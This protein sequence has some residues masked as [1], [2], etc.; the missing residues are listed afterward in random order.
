MERGK[1]KKATAGAAGA[2]GGSGEDKRDTF[3][4][5]DFYELAEEDPAEAGRLMAGALLGDG[6]DR[7]SPFAHFIAS[8]WRELL[9]QTTADESPPDIRAMLAG[10]WSKLSDAEKAAFTSPPS[11][12]A[13]ARVTTD[14]ASSSSTA[15]AV[16]TAASTSAAVDR[17]PLEPSPD[18]GN[19]YAEKLR[20]FV[21]SYLSALCTSMST[22]T[23][24]AWHIMHVK[25]SCS[26]IISILTSATATGIAASVSSGRVK[27]YTPSAGCWVWTG[28]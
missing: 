5:S 23:C 10:E 6:E 27:K 3:T 20:S 1:Q 11:F 26:L 28:T 9:D 18:E 12:A 8:K 2:A 25:C 24:I 7:D 13:A 16:S 19:A 17:A 4:S 15:T 14:E 22:G 21:Q